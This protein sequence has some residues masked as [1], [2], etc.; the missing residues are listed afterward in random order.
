MTNEG[1][2]VHDAVTGEYVGRLLARSLDEAKK[3]AVELWPKRKNV[4]VRLVVP[5]DNV[6]EAS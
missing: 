5:A 1:Y 2:I 3:T 6:D 4:T